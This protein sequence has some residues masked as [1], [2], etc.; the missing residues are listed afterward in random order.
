M[1]LKVG[2]GEGSGIKCTVG[3]NCVKCGWMTFFLGSHGEGH[4]EGAWV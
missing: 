4:I 3:A 1:C 2:G